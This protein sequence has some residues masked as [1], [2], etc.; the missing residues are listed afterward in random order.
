[1]N[2]KMRFCKNYLDLFVDDDL[3]LIKYVAKKNPKTQFYWLDDRTKITRLTEN[4]T[5][6]TNIE[7]MFE[8][9]NYKSQISNSK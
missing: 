9:K 3:S 4:I 2:L 7:Q 1:M 6:I 5:A 8:T